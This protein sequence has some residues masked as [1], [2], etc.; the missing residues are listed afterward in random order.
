MKLIKIIFYL[1][2]LAAFFFM[3]T[4]AFSQT[5]TTKTSPSPNLGPVDKKVQEASDAYNP[6]PKKNPNVYKGQMKEKEALDELYKREYDK[7]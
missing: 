7:K 6:P 4:S 5:K 2:V 1:S 3:S